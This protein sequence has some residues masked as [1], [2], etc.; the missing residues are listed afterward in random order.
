MILVPHEPRVSGGPA[1]SDLGT[2]HVESD[3]FAEH[4]PP[5]RWRLVEYR[6]GPIGALQKSQPEQQ[7]EFSIRHLQPPS[8]KTLRAIEWWIGNNVRLAPVGHHEVVA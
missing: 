1:S 6:V 4:P 3:S 7:R 8:D 5:A 2:F